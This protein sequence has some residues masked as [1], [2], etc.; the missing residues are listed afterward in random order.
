MAHYEAP[1][2]SA[3]FHPGMVTTSSL[4]ALNL[5]QPEEITML[6][7]IGGRI[8]SVLV[9]DGSMIKLA[10]CVEM[11]AGRPEEIETVLHPDGGLYRRR[12]EGQASADLAMWIR[13]GERG[14][15]PSV[16]SGMGRRGG[17]AAVALRNA[18]RK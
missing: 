3:G 8:L 16:A 4:A 18:R 14:V 7:K 10:R 5:M 1:F 6:V 9:L 13:I 15:A 2:R 12:A 17:T 11:D